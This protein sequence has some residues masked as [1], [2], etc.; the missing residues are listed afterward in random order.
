MAEGT[1]Q[2]QAKLSPPSTVRVGSI[3][4]PARFVGPERASRRDKFNT[5]LIFFFLQRTNDH[6]LAETS[7]QSEQSLS[8]SAFA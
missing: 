4:T 5:L 3:L 1:W 7:S 2:R 6:H 8:I